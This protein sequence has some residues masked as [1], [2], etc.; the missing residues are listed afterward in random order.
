MRTKKFRWLAVL[1]WMVV[2]FAFSHQ[3]YS[4]RETE[5]YLGDANVPVRKA[6]HISEYMIL[7]WLIRW[8]LQKKVDDETTVGDV[9]VD[10][11]SGD[12]AK[13]QSLVKVFSSA[14][15]S[16]F[17]L[18]IAYAASDE[19]HQSYVPGRSASVADVTWDAVGIT[20]GMVLLFIVSRSRKAR[21]P[22]TES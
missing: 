7:Y 6:G 18:S 4:G 17:L 2:I 9:N 13:A 21:G 19:W 11:T 1:V 22:E 3:A 16:A 8:A 14:E 10:T 20:L 5:K 12:G 15:T